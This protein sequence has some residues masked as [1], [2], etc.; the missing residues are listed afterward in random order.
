MQRTSPSKFQKRVLHEK[1]PLGPLA[2]GFLTSAWDLLNFKV[3]PGLRCFQSSI[4][5]RLKMPNHA[6]PQPSQPQ[7][8][9]SASWIV[10][11]A[12][13]NRKI[14]CGVFLLDSTP[15]WKDFERYPSISVIWIKHFFIIKYDA[16]SN[17]P[18]WSQSCPLNC[19]LALKMFLP[20]TDLWFILIPCEFDTLD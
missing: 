15:W 9:M 13:N 14:H 10:A 20:K 1:G 16:E 5:R 11:G 19:L 6:K 18:W 2:R 4:Y 7:S 3:L 8:T 17:L 12:Y